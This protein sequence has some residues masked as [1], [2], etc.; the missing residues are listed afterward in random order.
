MVTVTLV[1]LPLV[2]F[3]AWG[4]LF[5]SAPSQLTFDRSLTDEIGYYI[6]DYDE[7]EVRRGVHL[8]VAAFAVTSAETE[9]HPSQR[10]MSGASLVDVKTDHEDDDDDDDDDDEDDDCKS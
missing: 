3:P 7:D 1:L 8:E 2:H 4:S 6:S 10:S 9:R 5:Q